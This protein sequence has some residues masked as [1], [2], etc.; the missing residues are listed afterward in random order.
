M[1]H[2]P[3]LDGGAGGRLERDLDARGACS[4]R[5]GGSPCPGARRGARAPSTATRARPPRRS[6]ARSA[7]SP[8][9]G[10]RASMNSS[11]C[12]WRPVSVGARSSVRPGATGVPGGLGAGRCVRHRANVTR[13]DVRGKH[14]FDIS[15]DA[16]Q[17][18]GQ[19]SC[20]TRV[21]RSAGRRPH[22]PH[23]ASTRSRRWPQ[24]V[25]APVRPVARPQ[26][27]VP[28]PCPSPAGRR[29]P[30]AVAARPRSPRRHRAAAVYRRRRLVAAALGLG[31][32]A[33]GG[34]GGCGARRVLPRPRRAPP[35]RA[36]PVVVEPGDTL[37]SIAQR[38]RARVAI[39]R[40]VVDALVAGA[41]HRRA[42]A[43]A[44]RITWLDD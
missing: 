26:S 5:A 40:D 23:G 30:P 39:P 41:R 16:E 33:G 18:F 11:T 36:R 17:A 42:A 22:S 43:R 25:L 13:S 27:P 44:R 9:G 10:P 32:R 3:A 14:P 38:A 34:P 20:L 28:R 12:R 6:P 8:A 35:A 37:W 1:A 29:R 24:P 7:G 4:G 19:G 15:L 21:V 2:R 31:P